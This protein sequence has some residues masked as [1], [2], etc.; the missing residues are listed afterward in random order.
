M[1]KTANS[2]AP[3]GGKVTVTLSSANVTAMGAPF[4]TAE[5]I[6]ISGVVRSFE[7]T[8]N[9]EKGIE[10]TYVT[11]DSAPIVTSSNKRPREMWRLII[12]D[13]YSKGAAG[14]WGTDLITA[15]LL[16]RK[17]WSTGQEPPSVKVCPAF[18]PDAA[19]N[20]GKIVYELDDP[21]KIKA[22]G[23][24]KADADQNTPNEIEILIDC[25]SHTTS[26]HA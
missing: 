14:E 21:I 7:R 4:V 9:P 1:A 10:E 24:P 12:I 23:V 26:T 15:A 25:P 11:G 20:T 13:D 2:Y 22:V 5:E 18:D 8:N 16:F 17:L 6:T 19:S 3:S